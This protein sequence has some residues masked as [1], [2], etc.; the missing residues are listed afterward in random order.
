MTL[1]SVENAI[2]VNDE[3]TY[4]HWY[5]RA[6]NIY[7]TFQAKELL[8]VH[9]HAHT[10]LYTWM[11]EWMNG[12]V[13]VKFIYLFIF[14]HLCMAVCVLVRVRVRIHMYVRVRICVILVDEIQYTVVI[15]VAA[16][17]LDNYHLIVG[18]KCAYH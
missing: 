1:C 4:I 9:T 12:W 8:E 11:K 6:V 7:N 2:N 15:N 10:Y 3:M 13:N 17:I 18:N 5:I 14:F 16:I